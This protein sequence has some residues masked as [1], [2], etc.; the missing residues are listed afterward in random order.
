MLARQ[1][2]ASILHRLATFIL[3]GPTITNQ[4]SRNL[5]F[6]QVRKLCSQ[7]SLPDPLDVLASPPPRGKWKR[8]VNCQVQTYWLAK[9]RAE[10]AVLP[11]ISHFRCTHLSLSSPS[12]LITLCKFSQHEIKKLTVQLRMLSGRYRTCWLR[13]HWSGNADGN[14]EVPGC[15]PGTPG[16][17][18]H[19]ATG[20]CAGLASATAAASRQWAN[21]LSINTYLLNLFRCISASNQEDFLAFLLNP[22]THPEVIAL[23][24]QHGRGAMEDVSFLTRSW[25]Y[26]HHRARFRALGL[27]SC[28]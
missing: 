27:Y 20:Q 11:S 7:Y 23:A 5:W 16:T 8:Q 28:L 17:L 19:I 2:P 3:S 22:T 18:K 15:S 13:R 26:E 9:V 6:F 14:C 10:A 25:L 21:F 12:P 4:A 1:G 24:Q